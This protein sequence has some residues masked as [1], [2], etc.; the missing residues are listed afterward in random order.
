MEYYADLYAGM[1]DDL[2]EMAAKA[3]AEYEKAIVPDEREIERMKGIWITRMPTRPPVG[4]GDNGRIILPIRMAHAGAD[5]RLPPRPPGR[6]LERR[7]R[8]KVL[9]RRK[10][11]E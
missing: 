10:G 11:K 1:D 8:A 4:T 9:R 6:I 3:R 7:R 5:K 2:C